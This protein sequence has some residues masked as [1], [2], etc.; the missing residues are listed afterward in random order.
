[1]TDSDSDMP[2]AIEFSAAKKS[3]KSSQKDL[4]KA[5]LAMSSK[6]KR[7]RTRKEIDDDNDGD[8]NE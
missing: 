3:I 7:V 1:M 5:T 6:K 2:D 8:D 4:K